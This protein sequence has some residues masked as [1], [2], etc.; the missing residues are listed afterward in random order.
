MRDLTRLRAMLSTDPGFRVWLNAL[1]VMFWL[2]VAALALM[3]DWLGSLTF[4]SVLV[5]WAASRTIW[6]V[7]AGRRAARR[8][9]PPPASR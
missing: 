6:R 9:Q 2:A 3:M 5:I 4:A 7:M 8:G 1:L